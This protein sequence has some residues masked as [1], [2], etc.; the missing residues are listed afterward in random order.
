M[1]KNHNEK[2]EKEKMRRIVEELLKKSKNITPETV[3]LFV[4][5][6]NGAYQNERI[7]LYDGFFLLGAAEYFLKGTGDIEANRLSWAQG[8]IKA[9][10]D[11][12]IDLYAGRLGYGY[13]KH[14]RSEK[15]SRYHLIEYHIITY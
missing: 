11:G 15:S 10:D 9:E 3:R 5:E 1:T 6:V 7:T 14:I 12:K 4:S 2:K 8:Y 13:I